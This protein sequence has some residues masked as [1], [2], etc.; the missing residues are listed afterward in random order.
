[1]LHME[2]Q[3][4]CC[5]IKDGIRTAMHDASLSTLYIQSG[6]VQHKQTLLTMVAVCLH[7][8]MLVTQELCKS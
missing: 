5:P 8:C 7:L 1:M 2:V 4:L 3:G 6:S